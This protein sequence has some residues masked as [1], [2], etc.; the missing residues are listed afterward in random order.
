MPLADLLGMIMTRRSGVAHRFGGVWTEIK[1]KALNDYLG[2]YQAALKNQ[3]FETWYI[4][5]F[6]G[7]GDRHA[8]LSQGGIFEGGPIESVERILDGSA[9]KALK[10]VPPFSHYWFAEQHQGRARKLEQLTTEWQ[11]DIQVRRGEANVELQN[12]FAS[13]PWL[14]GST[15]AR[16]RAV[17][18]LDPYGMSVDWKTLEVLAATKK[19]DVWYLF[20]RAAVVHQLAND[21]SGV[22]DGKRRALAR[23]FGG[24]DWEAE[25]YSAKPAQSSLFE[26]A[27]EEGKARHASSADIADFARSRLGKLFCYVSDPLPLIVNG[28]DYFEL[29]CMSNNEKAI[30][31]I[32]K[33]VDYVIRKYTP[34]SRRRSGLRVDGR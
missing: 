3:N 8:E 11:Y 32:K 30:S 5:A 15:S 26:I 33:G 29:Y 19:V 28:H 6:A 22:D 9:R 2:F 25:F 23:I 16:Q 34:A 24:D 14:G 18:F 21:L 7:T 27:P 31:L 20:P 10:I 17:V 13:P 4:D 12:L 1:L